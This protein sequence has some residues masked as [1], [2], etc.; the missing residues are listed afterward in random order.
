M[1]SRACPDSARAIISSALKVRIERVRFLDR[2]F[3]RRAILRFVLGRA[4]RLLAA[5]AQPRQRRLEVVGDVV[6]DLLE[7]AHQ[8][9]D[10]IEHGVEIAGQP[11]E[12]VA[13]AGDRQTLGQIARH[14]G[15]RGRGHGVDALQH[16]ARHEQAAA[17]ARGRRR[18]PT[19]SDRRRS[20]RHACARAPRGRAR[21]AGESRPAA[22]RSRTSAWCSVCSRSSSCDRRSRSSRSARAR[23]RSAS[24]HCRRAPRLQRW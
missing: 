5:V 10:A 9:L 15:L 22:E 14:D 6:G 3:E 24:R 23:R 13:G 17:R 8:R 1:L 19:T 7:A 2:A 20:R 12:L 16:A 4:Q 21:P 18:S 11:V